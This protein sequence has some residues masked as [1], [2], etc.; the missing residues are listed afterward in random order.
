MPLSVQ[1]FVFL[2][3]SL[4]KISENLPLTLQLVVSER[5]GPQ[6]LKNCIHTHM[7]VQNLCVDIRFSAIIPAIDVDLVAPGASSL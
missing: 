5:L 2:L 4:Q 7:F 3:C 6:L 1:L